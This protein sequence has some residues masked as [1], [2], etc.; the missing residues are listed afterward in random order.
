MSVL[1]F[2]LV[3]ARGIH[4][5]C[6]LK[7]SFRSSLFLSKVL[8]RDQCRTPKGRAGCLSH[9]LETQVFSYQIQKFLDCPQIVRNNDLFFIISTLKTQSSK[10]EA[11]YFMILQSHQFGVKN[12]F[13]SQ[14]NSPSPKFLIGWDPQG[15]TV[16]LMSVLFLS[17]ILHPMGSRCK[18]LSNIPRL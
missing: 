13:P 2:I 7:H 11:L 3:R 8:G 1:L 5:F 17:Q 16:F 15:G 9:S 4:I 18:T 6:D 14:I 10:N 12:S